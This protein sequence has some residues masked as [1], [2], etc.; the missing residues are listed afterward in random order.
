V[1][2]VSSDNEIFLSAADGIDWLPSG[3]FSRIE[4]SSSASEPYLLH[5]D[6]P[7]KPHFHSN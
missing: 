1:P 5:P 6:P 3:G 2:Q 4:D 7:P